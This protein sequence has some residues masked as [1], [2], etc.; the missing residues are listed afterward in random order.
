MTDRQSSSNA[1]AASP[2]IALLQGGESPLLWL[3]VVFFCMGLSVI[4]MS[5]LMRAS[6]PTSVYLPGAS[7][8]MPEVC[9][10][11]R[12]FGVPCPGCGLT[13][14]FIAISHGQFGRAWGFNPAS[15]V[16]YPFVFAQIPWSAM[17]VWLIRTRGYGVHVPYIHF[18]PLA[19]AIVLL[20]QWLLK[21]PQ[22]LN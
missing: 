15:F 7:F 16:L 11:K 13:R 14:S 12:I 10:S 17:Q 18:L 21:L 20:V 2:P 1:E 5:F 22:L 19:V 3:H 6:G 8:A 4:G 9:T